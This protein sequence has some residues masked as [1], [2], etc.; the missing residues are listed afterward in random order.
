M[1]LFA[2]TLRWLD[3]RIAAAVAVTALLFNL[4]VMPRIGRGIY[5]DAARKRDAGIVAYPA[6]VLLLILLFRHELTLAAALWAMMAFGDPAASIAGK[7]I[8]GPRLPWNPKKTWIGFLAYA[9][10]GG[11]AAGALWIWVSLGVEWFTRR[12]VGSLFLVLGPVVLLGAFLESAETGLDD[13][14]IPAI[15]CAL[16]L[17]YELF[18]MWQPLYWDRLPSGN[19]VAALAVNASIAVV[20]GSLRIVRAS[21]ALAGFAV[22]FVILG[23]CG[24]SAYAVLLAFFL[25]GTVATR[26]G[27]LRKERRGTAQADRGRRGARHVLANC[28]VGTALCVLGYFAVKAVGFLFGLAFAASFAAA[29]A[30]TLGTEIGSL[31]GRQTFSLVSAKPVPAGTPGGVSF[32]GLVAGLPGAALIGVVS[33]LVGLVSWSFLWLVAAAGFLGSVAESLVRDLARSRGVS[34][35]HEFANAL[36]TFVGAVLAWY[37]AIWLQGLMTVPHLWRL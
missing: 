34:L 4:F 9:V 25:F 24:W 17:E 5:R 10:V 8:G 15:P 12:P 1:G 16:L 30:D 37:I 23:L 20:T 7:L 31:Y 36:N 29:L 2:L 13:N 22:G 14:W 21:G 3:W 18:L 28:G 35:D 6:M 32:A 27:F 11:I 26:L 33:C 19:W